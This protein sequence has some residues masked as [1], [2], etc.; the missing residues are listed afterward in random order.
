MGYS[1]GDEAEVFSTNL[2]RYFF[3]GAFYIFAATLV[4][5]LIQIIL[6]FYSLQI[7]AFATGNLLK[8]AYYIDVA[9]ELV[10]LSIFAYLI[11]RMKQKLVKLVI[12]TPDDDL[13]ID[14]NTYSIIGISFIREIALG[15]DSFC[16]IRIDD[17]EF[18]FSVGA[19]S[20]WVFNRYFWGKNV[21]NEKIKYL[22]ER[23][24]KLLKR[25][26]FFEEC[27]K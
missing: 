5:F 14:G 3:L 8:P 26:T 25:Q 27:K 15:G 7:E 16:W 6:K 4:F 12:I 17:R 21:R 23:R 11:L 13:I 24:A 20:S 2:G 1:I 19:A 10:L 22:H 9:I 18:I